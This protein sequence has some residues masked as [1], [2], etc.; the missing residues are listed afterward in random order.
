MKASD[1]Y[2]GVKTILNS[3]LAACAVAN[4]LYMETKKWWIDKDFGGT[5]EDPHGAESLYPDG[6]KGNAPGPEPEDIEWLMPEEYLK[7]GDEEEDKKIAPVFIKND[8]SANEIKQGKV[9]N[10]WLISALSVLAGHDELIM[11]SADTLDMENIDILDKKSA[12]SCSNGVFP[13]IFHKFRLK[14]I[15]VLRFYKDF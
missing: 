10:C 5:T 15:F 9:G 1:Y 4:Q 6:D 14:G 11:G 7:T 3:E 2:R 8:A 12:L 13:P